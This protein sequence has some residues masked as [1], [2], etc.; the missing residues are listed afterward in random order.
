[1]PGPGVNNQNICIALQEKKTVLQIWDAYPGSNF[2]HPGSR[3]D[4]RSQIRIPIKEFNY[5]NPKTDN[6]FSK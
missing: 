2:F 5:F 3:V 1:M 4:G 6:K